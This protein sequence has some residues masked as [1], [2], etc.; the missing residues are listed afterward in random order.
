MRKE[1]ARRGALAAGRAGLPALAQLAADQELY[2]QVLAR[3]PA[4]VVA[5]LLDGALPEQVAE[6][7]GLTLTELRASVARWATRCQREGHLSPAQ[8]TQI[9][10][11]VFGPAGCR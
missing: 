11:T 7:S 10:N 8:Y 2:R 6:A 5:A 9:L 3:R 1:I 4:L